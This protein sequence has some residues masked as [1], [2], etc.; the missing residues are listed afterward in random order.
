MKTSL[1]LTLPLIF[2]G[3]ALSAIVYYFA[4]TASTD[5]K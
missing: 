5:F 3:T 1:D 2:P 4:A